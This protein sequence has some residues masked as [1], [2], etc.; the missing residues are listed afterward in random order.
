MAQSEPRPRPATPCI[1]LALAYRRGDAAITLTREELRQVYFERL[2]GD[3]DSLG[4][5]IEAVAI[6]DL[7][8]PNRRAA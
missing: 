4:E 3:F 5:A 1:R 6:L 2:A 8:E 7:Y